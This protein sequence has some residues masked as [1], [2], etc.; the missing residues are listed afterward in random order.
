MKKLFFPL[1]LISLTVTMTY[2]FIFKTILYM[3]KYVKLDYEKLKFEVEY[4]SITLDL[5]CRRLEAIFMKLVNQKL[6]YLRI[7]LREGEAKVKNS[8]V[9]SI[10]SHLS[11]ILLQVRRAYSAI[12]KSFTYKIDTYNMTI[13]VILSFKGSNM[14]VTRKLH[15]HTPTPSVLEKAFEARKIILKYIDN[16]EAAFIKGNNT[17]MIEI[18]RKICSEI[19]KKYGFNVKW[20]LRLVRGNLFEIE[21]I[22]IKDGYSISFYDNFLVP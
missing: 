8:I 1:I 19:R 20:R 7:P 12:D 5:I 6:H 2:A 22:L 21:F 11:R 15:L 3:Q 16:M 18:A 14:S 17:R 13:I 4:Y 9:R 10:S